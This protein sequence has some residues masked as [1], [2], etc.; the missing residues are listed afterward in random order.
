MLFSLVFTEDIVEI[1]N[2]AKGLCGSAVCLITLMLT[3]KV[4][5][6]HKCLFK[7]IG[8]GK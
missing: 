3:N 2:G 1:W 5:T 6:A 4:Y 7:N 8:W